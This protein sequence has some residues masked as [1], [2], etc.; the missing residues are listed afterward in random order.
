MHIVRQTLTAAA[1]IAAIELTAAIRSGVRGRAL[2]IHAV[3]GI[4]L[5][6]L[7]PAINA[8]LQH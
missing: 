8:V 1:V 5:G 7:V 2:V 6:L 4:V 3:I